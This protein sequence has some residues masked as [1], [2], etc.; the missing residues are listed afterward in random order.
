MEIKKCKRAPQKK[1]DLYVPDMCQG[2]RDKR[3]EGKTGI[4]GQ[5]SETSCRKGASGQKRMNADIFLPTFIVFSTKKFRGL[6]VRNLLG[7]WHFLIFTVC[8][9]AHKS[10]ICSFH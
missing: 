3:N 10:F 5:T 4:F 6:S 2:G 8:L 9:S 7:H 1:N